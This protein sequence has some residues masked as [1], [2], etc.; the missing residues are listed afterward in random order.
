MNRIKNWKKQFAVIYTGQ[1]F[2]ILGS[3]AV[4]F[5]CYLVADHP[6]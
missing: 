5:R 4:Q 6:D 2:S 3:A 1:A